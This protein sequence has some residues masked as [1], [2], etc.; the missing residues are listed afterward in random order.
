MIRWLDITLILCIQGIFFSKS[1]IENGLGLIR[2]LSAPG[3]YFG[4]NLC[5]GCRKCFGFIFC[6]SVVIITGALY[7]R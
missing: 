6:L 5:I 4:R 1:G 3:I 2:R 7:M